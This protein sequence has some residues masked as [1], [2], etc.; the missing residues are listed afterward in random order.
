MKKFHLSFLCLPPRW[1]KLLLFMKI[2]LLLLTIC[3]LQVNAKL[4][5]QDTRFNFRIKN[6]TLREVL[7]EIESKSDF[8]FFFSD[9]L[10]LLDKSVNA[11]IENLNVSQ[12][13]DQLL[14]NSDY[15]YKVL[16]DKLIVIAPKN[17]VARQ[18]AKVIGKVTDASSGAALP[19]VSVAIEGTST[20]A[21][22]D[23]D[24]NYVI[25]LSSP[26]AT[27]VFTYIGYLPERVKITDQNTVSIALTP[28]I[29]KLNEIVVVGYGTQ[30]RGEVTSSVAS[31]K[32]ED[33]N[34]GGSRSALDLIQ[35]K[36]AGLTITRT[37]GN[38]PN[39]SASIQLRGI[40]SLTG[41]QSPLIVI[42]GIPGG[43]L[44]LLQQDEIESFDI[45]KDGSAAAIYGS[46][47]NGGVILVTTKK[48]TNGPAKFEYST[49]FSKDFLAKKPDFLTADEYRAL[50]N[51]PNNTRAGSMTDYGYSTDF[52]DLLMNKN[53]LSQYHSLSLSGGST[54]TSYRGTLFYNDLNGIARKNGRDN[55]GARLNINQKGF[56]DLLTAQINI[57][58]NYNKANLIGGSGFES[59]LSRN[60]TQSVYNADGTYWEDAT[61]T[62]EIARLAQ[63]SYWRIQQ[64]SSAD[65]LLT[66]NIYGGLKASVSGSLQRDSY[67][68]NWYSEL[69]SKTSQDSYNGEGYA[70]KASNM[71]NQYTIEPKL[72]Y[73]TT[74][75][76]N[77]T[78]NAFA[79]YSYQYKVSESFKSENSGFV[80]DVF[81]E[82]NLGAGTY[83]SDGKAAMSSNKEDETL[84]AFF[85]R[86]N[87]A[88]KDRYMAQFILRHEGSSK[89]GE[90]HKW[91][92]F[93]A[94][95]IG[96]NISRENFMKD[97]SL[98]NNLKI[99]AGYGITGNSGIGNYNSIV[100]LGT[101]NYY[102][103]PDG[104]WKQT[105]GPS[106]NPNPNLK[107]EK[108]K[109]LNIGL[110]FAILDSKLGGSVDV[111]RRKTVD[112]LESYNTQLPPYIQSTI[113]TNV[114]TIE[115]NGV[116]ITINAIPIKTNNFTWRST[117]TASHQSNILKTFSN[118]LYKITYK[119]YGSIGGYG[120]LGYAIRTVEGGKLGNFYGKRFAGFTDEG[121]WLFYSADGSKVN[122]D[123][124][125][126]AD[127]TV[128]G[129]GIP[130]YYASWNN[131]IKYK[132]FDL[133]IFLRGK[134]GF[135]I[136]NTRE[137]SY[138]NVTTLPTNILKSALTKHSQLKDT[139]QYSDYYLESGS[140]VKLDNVTLGY[141]FKIKKAYIENVR[142]YATVKNLATITGYSG[143]N[144]EVED[145]GLA[146]GIDDRDAYPATRTFTVGLNVEF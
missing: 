66:L 145:T 23:L 136:L 48:G 93:P 78:F 113:Y 90:N 53:N 61:T 123:D 111:Y 62:N 71:D 19:G 133:S 67:N 40:T 130:K 108:K 52:Y 85:G 141:N 94:A 110:D 49:Y 138:G 126:D 112:L 131:Q 24:G 100:T 98:V 72:E 116:E 38:N 103:F 146:P 142:V 9:N 11:D 22:T 32:A 25:E 107:W 58:T 51:D 117:I 29:L 3:I 7:Q 143:T 28:D 122:S 8:R 80:N 127:K 95:S 34:A 84:I 135:D 44:D 86:L 15:S 79:G 35:G 106:K 42:D 45:L 46:R 27:L 81:R 36:V 121:K 88:Y 99:R 47:A 60:P 97:F 33:F 96:W 50:K 134:F 13:L 2:S 109:E 12:I 31:V 56:H 82:N 124:V 137:L 55:Y 92:N 17:F 129:N 114:G 43:N 87:Y 20:G 26:G 16:E 59:S 104:T 119:E 70:Y 63:N 101:G 41:D 54:N 120:D 14:V 144:P 77:H 57:A 140:F 69:A 128:I 132:N 74:L 39:S 65:G 30:K 18:Q 21:V 91:G 6:Q 89:F 125:T 5:S 102:I 64:T 68:D 4:Y 118:Q 37:S 115:N 1:K 75:F 139:Y 10:L 76:E 73:S 83:L 105:Y